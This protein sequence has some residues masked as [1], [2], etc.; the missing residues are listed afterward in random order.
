M[1][2]SL[3][4]T[5]A[6][7]LAVLAILAN[8]AS[9]RHVQSLCD[10]L[11]PQDL[12]QE[13]ICSEPEH[14][15]ALVQ[16]I[17]PFNGTFFNDTI[18][19][20]F[21]LDICNALSSRISLDVTERNHNIDFPVEAIRAGE[22]KNIPI[23]G[24]SLIVPHLGSVGVDVT[25]LISGNPDWLKLKV[26]LNAC[27]QVHHHEICGSNIPGLRT[28]LPWYILNGQYSFGDVCESSSTDTKIGHLRGIGYDDNIV[29]LE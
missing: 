11:H 13:C 4:L 27:L 10:R 26:G 25:V 22:E 18:G 15:H 12:P 21:D 5:L 7:V 9:S 19:I 20:T 17:K 28:E 3:C 14:L 8:T 6:P 2:Q 1:P 24:L 23:P 29:K 16:C